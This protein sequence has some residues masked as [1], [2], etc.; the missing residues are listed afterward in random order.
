M[1]IRDR[2]TADGVENGISGTSLYGDSV[3]STRRT[4]DESSQT[5]ETYYYYWVTNKATLPNVENRVTTAFDVARYIA[6]PTQMGYRFVA[7]LGADRFALYNCSPFITDQDTAIS[8]NW[9]TIENQEQ[10]THIQYQLI[11]D[12]LETSIPNNEIEQKWFDSLVAVS[13]THLTLPTIYS[14]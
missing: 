14:V 8:F 12:G 2:S 9:W 4:Y 10:P 7:M 11:S 3:Y 5:F 6:N 13:Y 1:C